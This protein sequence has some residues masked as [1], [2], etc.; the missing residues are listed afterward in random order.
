MCEGIKTGRRCGIVKNT[1]RSFETV[2]HAR[3]GRKLVKQ[4]KGK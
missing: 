4:P 1:R 3:F 2:V